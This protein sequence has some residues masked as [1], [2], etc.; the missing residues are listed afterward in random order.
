MPRTGRSLKT[1]LAVGSFI[2][3]FLLSMVVPAELKLFPMWERKQCGD[4]EFACYDF[5]TSKKILKLDIDLQSKL[6]KLDIC[7]KDKVDLELS[8][9]KLGDA[10]TLL[11]GNIERLETRLKEKNK[12]LTDNTNLMVKYQARDVFGGA[13]PWVITAVV[14]M[15]AAGFVGGYYIG[16]R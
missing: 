2:T 12:V 5:E 15:A 4:T 8:I 13:L 1:K 11:Q 7:L 14:V 9:K 16:T 3:V 10:S 6:G